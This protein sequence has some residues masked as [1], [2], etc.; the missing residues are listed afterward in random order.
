MT[1]LIKSGTADNTIAVRSLAAART[2]P[3]HA[4]QDDEMAALRRR[5]AELDSAAAS[6]RANIERLRTQN[7]QAVTEAREAGR[8]QGLAEAGTREAERLQLLERNLTTARLELSATLPALERLAVLLARDCLEMILGEAESRADLL[9]AI[10][11][12]QLGRIERAAVLRV[13]LSTADFP[14]GEALQ[15]FA[16]RSAAPEICFAPDATLPAG[17]C[18]I[19]LRLGEIEVG[20]DRQWPAMRAFLDALA[21]PEGVA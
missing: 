6:H 10:I 5:I 12:T 16:A 1:S 15:Q 2:P 13:T 14:D 19:S 21:L 9:C 20:L 4:P 11:R 7:Q 17:G 8:K 3:P 18:R